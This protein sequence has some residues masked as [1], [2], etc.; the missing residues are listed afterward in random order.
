MVEPRPPSAPGP[1]PD[2]LAAITRPPDLTTGPGSRSASLR[3][4]LADRYS[5]PPEAFVVGAGTASL[6]H[7]LIAQ[8]AVSGGGETVYSQPSFHLYAT[9]THDY[10]LTGRAVPLRDYHHDLPALA[11]AVSE[12]TQVVLL[13]SPQHHRNHRAA[14]RRDRPRSDRARSLRGRSRQRLR[15]VPGRRP[16]RRVVPRPR[17]VRG[18]DHRLS[19]LQQGIPAVRTA[20]RVHDRGPG[21]AGRTRADAPTDRHPKDHRSRQTDATDRPIAQEIVSWSAVL[22]TNVTPEL[23]GAVEWIAG[24]PFP[25]RR[26]PMRTSPSLA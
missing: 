26:S 22:R 25:R 11:R 15:R 2:A 20:G 6:L 3:N 21:S 12:R 8:A 16:V 18:A 23:G 1:P 24:P 13:D 17:Q 14:A 7:H 10:G 5:V 9:L 19:Q 4:A